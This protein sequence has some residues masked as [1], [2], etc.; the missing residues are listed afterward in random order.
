MAF[1]GLACAPYCMLKS[2]EKGIRNGRGFDGL[3]SDSLATL[4]FLSSHS[5]ISA[6][7]VRRRMANIGSE[8]HLK[9]NALA[10]V[11]ADC[12]INRVALCPECMGPSDCLSL[13]CFATEAN[14]TDW[15]RKDIP[16]GAFITIVLATNAPACHPVGR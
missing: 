8:V 5:I 7:S 3:R 13:S 4:A 9:D 16:R 14:S 10:K 2:I 11:H 12:S 6:G 1:W 15:L